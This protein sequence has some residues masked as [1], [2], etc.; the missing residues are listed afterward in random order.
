M[1]AN[2]QSMAYMGEKPWHGLGTRVEQSVHA[3]KMLCA[4]GLDWEVTTR[5]ARGAKPICK[6]KGEEIYSRYEIVRLPRI[7]QAEEE[8]VFGIVTERYEPLQNRDAF[9]FFDTI[10]DRKI[11]FF[12]TAGALGEGER[13]WIL[14]KMPEAITV[15]RG[16]ECQKY[17]LLSNSHTGKGSIIV[18]FTAVRVVCQNTLMLAIKNGQQA[19]RVRHSKVMTDRLREISGLISIANAVYANAAELFRRLSKIDLTGPLLEKYLEAVF[20]KSEA[21]KKKGKTPPKWVHVM[22]LLE[23]IDDLQMKGVRGTLWAAYN[24]ITRFED[25]RL[26]EG[27]VKETRLNRVWFGSGANAKLKALEKAAEFAKLN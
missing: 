11:A 1:P 10:V 27:E 3:D 13:V 14:A 16:D 23:E 7:G 20:P 5:P 22:Q 26:I 4:A 8:V 2:V 25:Y 9:G 15:V 18:K 24:A 12:E 6:R 19:F 17:L 21:Q